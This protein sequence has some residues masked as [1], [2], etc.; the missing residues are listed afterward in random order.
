M[1]KQ[2]FRGFTTSIRQAGAIR[3]GELMPSRETKF[4]PDEIEEV[5]Y[6]FKIA[7]LMISIAILA[8][9]FTVLA[10]I[11]RDTIIFYVAILFFLASISHGRRRRSGQRGEV[12]TGHH[13]TEACSRVNAF[14]LRQPRPPRIRQVGLVANVSGQCSVFVP[15]L[16]GFVS[17]DLQLGEDTG[18]YRL[19]DLVVDESALKPTEFLEIVY[20]GSIEDSVEPGSVT[21]CQTHRTGLGRCVD[22][23]A[24][25]FESSQLCARHPDCV[26]L[27]VP[28]RVEIVDDQVL[29]VGDDLSATIDNNGPKNAPRA[30]LDTGQAR[31]GDR[32]AHECFVLG[33]REPVFDLLG[34]SPMFLRFLAIPSLL[35]SVAFGHRL[36]GDR[37]SQ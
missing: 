22:D 33:R 1:K 29:S 13:C 28:G 24:V 37:E 9:A 26:N 25:E 34:R 8:V 7:H 30:L 11:S 12:L 21:S 18:A 27:R 10:A 15:H 2:H 23:A 16:H 32:S 19:A 36:P 4:P 5:R 20:L 17:Q 35:C 14:A 31:I 6:R 3:R